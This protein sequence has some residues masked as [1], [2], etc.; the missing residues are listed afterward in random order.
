MLFTDQ[1]PAPCRFDEGGPLVQ[2]HTQITTVFMFKKKK[3]NLVLLV[4]DGT[5]GTVA[6]GIFSK[7]L[8]CDS[9]M[10]SIYTKLAPYYAFFNKNAKTQP[11]DICF[12]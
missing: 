2:V 9:G 6:V 10:P 3:L 11:T 7:N 5:F 1:E 4:Q 12:N 8:V